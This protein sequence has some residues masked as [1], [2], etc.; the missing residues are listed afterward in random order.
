MGVAGWRVGVEGTGDGVGSEGGMESG[1]RWWE[2]SGR[3][4]G[5]ATGVSARSVVEE[6]GGGASFSCEKAIS[7]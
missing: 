3:E 5:P 2:R 4:D 7:H 6:G 1:W